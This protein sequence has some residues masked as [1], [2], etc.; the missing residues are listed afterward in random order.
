MSTIYMSKS[1]SFIVRLTRNHQLTKHISNPSI[2][3]VLEHYC[4]KETLH[5][6]RPHVG[7]MA[8]GEAEAEAWGPPVTSSIQMR[9]CAAEGRQAHDEAEALRPSAAATAQ[10]KRY[11]AEGRQAHGEAE[12]MGPSATTTS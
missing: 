8:H 5:G 9:R 6:R 11:V 3:V 12:A 1:S 10:R 7:R 2:V 4:P